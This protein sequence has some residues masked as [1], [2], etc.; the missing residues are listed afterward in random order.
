MCAWRERCDGVTHLADP[1]RRMAQAWG[2][3][4]FFVWLRPCCLVCSSFGLRMS[5]L[6]TCEWP[7]PKLHGKCCISTCRAEIYVC[8]NH[9]ATWCLRAQ[10]C[11][12]KKETLLCPGHAREMKY[13]FK[14]LDD[15]EWQV[16]CLGQHEPA[17]PWPKGFRALALSPPKGSSGGDSSSWG[18]S[19][20]GASS[21]AWAWGAAGD[22]QA[23][24]APPPP[25]PQQAWPRARAVEKMAGAATIPPPQP[26]TGPPPYKAVPSTPPMGLSDPQPAI[27]DGTSTALAGPYVASPSAFELPTLSIGVNSGNLQLGSASPRDHVLQGVLARI[28]MLEAVVQQVPFLHATLCELQ[29]RVG[30]LEAQVSLSSTVFAGLDLMQSPSAYQSGGPAT[31][32]P[33]LNARTAATPC[34]SEMAQSDAGDL[35]ELA[36]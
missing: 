32:P 19:S 25:P 3:C 27:T 24:V 33:G 21:G 9:N 2:H 14:S 11:H 12:T 36:G 13:S 7:Q 10:G 16:T 29:Q 30:R 26:P 28:T 20:W 34:P 23:S 5:L 1:R 6:W 4:L 17:D 31:G 15:M 8:R 35:G 18:A 22:T